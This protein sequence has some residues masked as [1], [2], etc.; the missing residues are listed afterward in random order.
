MR[1]PP[2]R[3]QEHV[4]GDA[5]YRL[6]RLEVPSAARAVV[7]DVLFEHRREGS[8]FDFGI[9]VKRLIG[10]P[11]DTVHVDDSPDRCAARSVS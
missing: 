1:Q 2:D 10:L 11:G 6:G 9:Y 5:A 3:W 7:G 4:E 8:S